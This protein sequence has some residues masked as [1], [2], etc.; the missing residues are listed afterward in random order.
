MAIILVTA[1]V[2]LL[3]LPV[4]SIESVFGDIPRSFHITFPS[5]KIRQLAHYLTPA[6]IIVLLSGIESLLSAVVADRM[7]GGNHRSN[8]ELIAQGVANIVTPVFGGIPASGAIARAATSVKNRERA[9]VAGIVHAIT[10]LLIML[11]FGQWVKLIPMSCLVGILI[12]AA[13]NMSEWRLFVSILKGSGFD[14]PILLVTF[15]LTVWVDLTY[16]I[17]IGIVRSALLIMK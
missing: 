4:T 1:V 9:P 12:V 17:Q 10:L 11:F 13:Y 5:V 7:I 14:I 6:L 2:Q 8:T 3:K 15:F 16:A